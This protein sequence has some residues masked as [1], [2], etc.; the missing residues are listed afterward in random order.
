MPLTAIYSKG[1]GSAPRAQG[2]YVLVVNGAYELG[3][4]AFTTCDY[5]SNVFRERTMRCA[6]RQSLK[7][8]VAVITILGVL[9]L[10][11]VPVRITGP[12]RSL[13][14]FPMR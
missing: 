10:V 13:P 12:Q 5:H 2:Y 4:S 3:I 11:S 6:L 14:Y 1:Y 7:L 9:Y 8:R